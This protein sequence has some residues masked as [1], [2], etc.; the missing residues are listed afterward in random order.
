M[1]LINGLMEI[2]HP[3]YSKTKIIKY[4]QLTARNKNLRQNKLITAA[5][6]N[7]NGASCNLGNIGWN[8]PIKLNIMSESKRYDDSTEFIYSVNFYFLFQE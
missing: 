7:C 2:Y 3:A 8:I 6:H 4:F 5:I 1:I